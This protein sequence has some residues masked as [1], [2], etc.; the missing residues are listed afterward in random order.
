M[1]K[2]RLIWI[3][4]TILIIWLFPWILFG[5]ITLLGFL[6]WFYVTNP[7][8][9]GCSCVDDSDI[10]DDVFAQQ[11]REE[12]ERAREEERKRRFIEGF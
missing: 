3:L 12:E 10:Y 9:S 4:A 11:Q 7:D 2:K 8:T 6:I 1:N 5:A